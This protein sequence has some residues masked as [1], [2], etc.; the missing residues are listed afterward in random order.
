MSTRILK[1]RWYVLGAPWAHG[2]YA[3]TMIL[4]GSEDPHMADP[5]CDTV[6]MI[7]Q[8]DG[9][10]IETARDIAEHIIRLHNASLEHLQ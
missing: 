7:D 2:D 9:A 6:D 8:V 1:V 5:V 10:D 4:A 3:G